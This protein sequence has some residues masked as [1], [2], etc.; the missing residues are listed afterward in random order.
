M[1]AWPGGSGAGQHEMSIS[2]RSGTGDFGS[3]RA[4]PPPGSCAA[5]SCPPPWAWSRPAAGGRKSATP[6]AACVRSPPAAPPAGPAAAVRAG[7]AAAGSPAQC[8]CPVSATPASSQPGRFAPAAQP[9]GPTAAP[10]IVLAA[11][12]LLQGGRCLQAWQLAQPG[13]HAQL[14]AQLEA[15][16]SMRGCPSAGPSC[17]S[18]AKGNCSCQCYHWAQDT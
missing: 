12:T 7:A 10:R 8:R 15:R 1:H 13:K 16:P 11:A 6:R 3:G 5:G 9:A 18:Q 4:C 17:C 14:A 2:H